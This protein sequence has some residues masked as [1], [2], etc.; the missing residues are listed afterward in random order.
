MTLTLCLVLYYP[1]NIR[2]CKNVVIYEATFVDSKNCRQVIQELDRCNY[3]QIA[4]SP[5]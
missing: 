3:F 4:F 1:I 5:N 2:F